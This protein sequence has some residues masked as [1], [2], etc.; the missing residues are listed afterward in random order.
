MPKPT[1]PRRRQLAAAVRDLPRFAGNEPGLP[2]VAVLAQDVM[3]TFDLVH[4]RLDALDAQLARLVDAA[5]PN[6][7]DPAAW[8]LC[9]LP[10]VV[11]A[12]VAAYAEA[13]AAATSDP[14]DLAAVAANAPDLF[15]EPTRGDYGARIEAAAA[16]LRL[17]EPADGAGPGPVRVEHEHQADPPAWVREMRPCWRCGDSI[18]NHDDADHVHELAAVVPLTVTYYVTAG[19][20][21]SPGDASEMLRDLFEHVLDNSTATDAL[22]AGLACADTPAYLVGNNGAT[23]ENP[24]AA[25]DRGHRDGYEAHRLAPEPAR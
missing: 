17:A 9:Q 8:P 16:A 25:Y 6:G 7:T 4:E 22:R 12:I 2:R 14:D 1:Y 20:E 23:L 21:A 3:Q 10:P 13:H 11:A 15:D 5:D 24:A 18:D 19:P